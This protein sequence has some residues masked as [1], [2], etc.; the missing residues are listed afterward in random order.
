MIWMFKWCARRFG[1]IETV[2]WFVL[3]AG[4]GFIF[5]RSFVLGVTLGVLSLA[6][7]YGESRIREWL[8]NRKSGRSHG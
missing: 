4:Y 5:L 3:F 7:S 6:L 2:F 8:R 1:V